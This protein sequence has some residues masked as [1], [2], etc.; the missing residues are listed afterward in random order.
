MFK[1]TIRALGPSTPLPTHKIQVSAAVEGMVTEILA[2]EGEKVKAGQPLVRLDD[3]LAQADLA[4]RKGARAEIEAGLALLKALPREP[5]RRAAD[6][7]VERAG[8]A[9][10][11]AKAVLDRLEPL[12]SRKEVSDQQLYEAKLK[13]QDAQLSRKMAE[14]KRDALLLGPK[15]EAV[16]E[17]EAK[18][19]RAEASLNS[20]AARLSYF[21][22]TASREGTVNAVLCH[23]GQVLPAGTV[24]AE[25]LDNS[26]MLVTVFVPPRDALRLSEGLDATV[27]ALNLA[28]KEQEGSPA[29]AGKVVFVASE[30]S[31]DTGTFPVRVHV[32]SPEG[33]LRLGVVMSVEIV[34]KME[35]ALAVPD[36]A[37]VNTEDGLTI[38]LVRAEKAVPLHPILGLKSG[39]LT[40]VTCEGLK[41]GD[42]VI[43]SGA[44]DLKEGAPVKVEKAPA[45]SEA[46]K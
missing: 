28:T 22:L 18:L 11:L 13:L 45:A 42:L 41:E 6:L 16:A 40:Q 37:I 31:A 34:L 7:D 3:R 27:S 24:A 43:T 21:T 17:T 14:A 29:L 25:V 12:N 36:E 19:V 23:P 46:S 30:A 35:E 8:L 32:S 4:E 9:A 1:E 20:A 44:Y 5:E 38:F 26:E 10:D 39:G 2:H 33:R 15:P